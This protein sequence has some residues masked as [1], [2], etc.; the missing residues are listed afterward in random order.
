MASVAH[1]VPAPAIRRADALAPATPV[2]GAVIVAIRATIVA[3]VVRP[4]ERAADDGASGQ[5]A[6]D[7][8]AVAPMTGLGLLRD[9]NRRHG[10][11]RGSGESC[12]GLLHWQF[13]H[14][15]LPCTENVWRAAMF[16][17]AAR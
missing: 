4:G 1:P 11:R 15:S 6:E 14:H 13:P 10:D 9:R 7:C 2:A 12:Q 3:V 16:R 17:A 5:A 8:A